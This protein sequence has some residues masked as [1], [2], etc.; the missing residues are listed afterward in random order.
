MSNPFAE[1][2]V[3]E[4]QLALAQYE[5]VG[6]D[7]E[8]TEELDGQALRLHSVRKQERREKGKQQRAA[9]GGTTSKAKAASSSQQITL[10]DSQHAGALASQSQG[11]DIDSVIKRI[12][13]SSEEDDMGGFHDGAPKQSGGDAKSRALLAALLAQEGE[14]DDGDEGGMF[15]FDT[16]G[17]IDSILFGGISK[18]SCAEESPKLEDAVVKKEAETLLTTHLSEYDDGVPTEFGKM[19]KAQQ[20]TTSTTTA[21]SPVTGPTFK[22]EKRT[23]SSF[24]PSE[25]KLTSAVDTASGDLAASLTAATATTMTDGGAIRL[26]ETHAFYWLDAKEVPHNNHYY[27][28]DRGSVTLF[29]KIVKL[30]AAGGSSSYPAAESCCVRVR[31]IKRSVL[32]RSVIGAVEDDVIGEIV[33]MCNQVGITKFTIKPVMRYFVFEEPEVNSEKR[34]VQQWYKL[35]YSASLPPL[36]LPVPV[37]G[38]TL[39]QCPPLAGYQF[40]NYHVG[41]NRNLRELLLIKRRLNRGPCYLFFGKRAQADGTVDDQQHTYLVPRGTSRIS[42]CK[43]E[44]ICDEPKVVSVWGEPK[45]KRGGTA[46]GKTPMPHPATPAPPTLT[47]MSIQILTQLNPAGNKNEVYGICV[48]IIR[49]GILP[50]GGKKQ[51]PP[52]DHK[53]AVRPFLNSTDPTNGAAGSTLPADVE[54]YCEKQGGGLK[55]TRQQ[56]EEQLLYWLLDEIASADPDMLLG[57]NF[58]SFT[59]DVLLH[60]MREHH[61]S[62]WSFLGRLRQTSP[63]Q[64][65]QL[66]PG[67]GGMR[68]S[69]IQEKECCWGRL[70]I[71]TYLLAREHYK[72]TN[73]K[74]LSLGKELGLQGIFKGGITQAMIEERY[75]QGMQLN[76]DDE[77]DEQQQQQSAPTQLLTPQSMTSNSELLTI[78]GRQLNSAIIVWELAYRLD[79]IP[80]T[81]QLCSQAGSVWSRVLLGS[82]SERIE[83]LLLHA[84]HAQKHITPDKASFA[85][86]AAQAA[87]IVKAETAATV[88]AK[89]AREATGDGATEDAD[90]QTEYDESAATA[91]TKR[92]PKY[93]GGLVLEP[94]AGLYTNY[95]LL[96]DFNS[97]YPSLIQEFHICFS[98]VNRSAKPGFQVAPPTHSDLKCRVCV[99]NNVDDCPHK[100]IL[101]R[102]IERLV[103]SRR[104]VKQMM[105]NERRE[106]V[107]AQLDIRQ[108]A[109]KLTANSMYGCLGFEHSRFFARPLAEL[110]TSQGRETLQNTQKMVPTIVSSVPLEVIYGDT[111]S[112]MLATGVKDDLAMVR[113]LGNEVKAAVN[114]KYRKL[115]I[116][117]DGVFRSI[118]LMKKKKYAALAVKD[119]EGEGKVFNQIVKGLDMVRRDWCALSQQA[120]GHILSRILN[121]QPSGGS[122][123]EGIDEEEDV[124]KFVVDFM[125]RLASNVRSGTVYELEK[126]II[127]KSLTKEPESYKGDSFPHAAVAVRMKS[128][129]IAVRVGDLIPYIICTESIDAAT[130]EV[131]SSGG[132]STAKL[133]T[134]A[135]HAD[136]V[137]KDPSKLHIDVEWYLSTQIFPPVL[138]ICEYITGFSAQQ[139]AEAMKLHNSASYAG[140]GGHDGISSMMNTSGTV[141]SYDTQYLRHFRT[142]SLEECFPT[143]LP[144]QAKCPQCKRMTAIQPHTYLQ[145]QMLPVF[146]HRCQ[147]RQFLLR[148]PGLTDD[149]RRAIMGEPIMRTF[150]LYICDACH[151]SLTPQY[152][153]N[154][155]TLHLRSKIQG[156]YLGGGRVADLSQIQAQM[157]YLRALFDVPHLPGVSPALV[158]LHRCCAERCI[159]TDPRRPATTLEVMDALTKK[160]AGG[161]DD[162]GVDIPIDP[163][164]DAV[165]RVYR[166]VCGMRIDLG[167]IFAELK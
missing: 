55:V 131:V 91:T 114:K 68:E 148:S 69:T 29:G 116:D 17:S 111:D 54:M 5:N 110:V 161:T 129:N 95:V 35:T 107:Y 96:L 98:T 34:E 60:R 166:Q 128:R 90:G 33:T 117:I 118:L 65:P 100:R 10:F 140:V 11:I 104:V 150:P 30:G 84:F 82:R 134:R 16:A 4:L 133:S 56:N 21:A 135:F 39:A 93:K 44:F 165:D 15:S 61:I 106:D 3:D 63:Q 24:G 27:A 154:V 31:N 121:P 38:D 80:L 97:L 146:L 147:E 156:F 132:G 64:F 164:L 160:S 143:A 78:L 71:D 89:R 85:T 32:L 157:S 112:V 105:K 130:G 126:F 14:D 7:D 159:Y 40:I 113:A 8:E 66:Q 108:L 79:V 87:A 138:R 88:G 9:G 52:V 18:P 50:D 124:V 144:I 2:E 42:H 162:D 94:K 76:D 83:Y 72:S 153:A 141:A 103:D 136:E 75:D 123:G 125:T 115:E 23:A 70:L 127:N 25:I 145:Q 86:K 119:W 163:V 142:M 120:S 67:A 20:H 152:V 57:H 48:A 41:A 101:P 13:A 47:G 28:D 6:A 51:L 158:A 1:E 99:D 151:S 46:V 59:L 139:L 149:K 77:E 12:G 137:R 155:V 43:H 62:T 45:I 102:T 74:L 73:Y 53:I 36:S 167:S 92:Q 37:S 22:V 58:I 26:S 81:K 109:I 122:G 49:N 19:T